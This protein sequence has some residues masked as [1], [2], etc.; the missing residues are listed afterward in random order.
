ME[1]GP[2]MR[3]MQRNPWYSGGVWGSVTNLP[4]V[5]PQTLLGLASCLPAHHLVALPGLPTSSFHSQQEVLGS[6]WVSVQGR[7][8]IWAPKP[9]ARHQVAPQATCAEK[10]KH[11]H[12]HPRLRL[13]VFMRCQPCMHTQPAS[14][15]TSGF[16]LAHVYKYL[17]PHAHACSTLHT[18]TSMLLLPRLLLPPSPCKAK[19]PESGTCPRASS[20]GQ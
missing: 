4:E 18:N 7:D 14:T 9:R 5:T 12:T 13:G 11:T 1:L 19:A 8:H 2:G 6:F 17:F 16:S 3:D 20:P 15:H 10:E